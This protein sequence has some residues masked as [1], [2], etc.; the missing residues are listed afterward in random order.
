VQPA[1]ALLWSFEEDAKGG[2]T[3]GPTPVRRVRTKK[4]H[5]TSAHL[6]VHH[7]E[8]AVAGRL[9]KGVLAG[10]VADDKPGV[11]VQP[12]VLVVRIPREDLQA[13]VR[14]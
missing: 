8:T 7:L 6:T 11:A 3:Y 12:P 10:M 2:C 1:D 9:D 5:V 13:A 14:F 4:Q